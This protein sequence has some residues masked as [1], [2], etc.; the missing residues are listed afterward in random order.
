MN[1]EEKFET[2][3]LN[4]DLLIQNL[5]DRERFQE[6]PYFW[7]KDTSPL[8]LCHIYLRSGI[9]FCIL[10]GYKRH[11]IIITDG[12]FSQRPWHSFFDKH[13]LPKVDSQ[14]YDALLHLS[15]LETRPVI[16]CWKT[17]FKK[18]SIL[19]NEVIS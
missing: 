13:S 18:I 12:A 6:N 9:H 16:Y 4:I 11:I 5:K 7:R 14:F 2:N 19:G 8:F 17:Y 15:I 3:S 10:Q 1:I